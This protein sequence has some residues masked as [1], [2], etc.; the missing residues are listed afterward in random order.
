MCIRNLIAF[1]CVL[2]LSLFQLIFLHYFLHVY[3]FVQRPYMFT[4]YDVM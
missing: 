3:F 2:V 4:H 1:V